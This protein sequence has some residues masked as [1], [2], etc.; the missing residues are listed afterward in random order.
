MKFVPPNTTGWVFFPR[1][2]QS[3]MPEGPVKRRKTSHG[4]AAAAM[5][6]KRRARIIPEIAKKSKKS[7]KEMLAP[8]VVV[9]SGLKEE[10][11]EEKEEGGGEGGEEEVVVE[12]EEKEE[13]KKKE[14]KQE[15]PEIESTPE[16]A[17]EELVVVKDFKELVLY[18]L[19]LSGKLLI[20]TVLQGVMDSLCEACANLGYKQ[21]T[22]IQVESIPVA[23]EGKDVIALAETGSGKTAA[24]ALPILQGQC[25]YLVLHPPQDPTDMSQPSGTTPRACL[26]AFSHLRVNS[27]S[28]SRI[29][30]RPSAVELACAV[31]SLLVVWT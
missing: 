15:V 14:K 2:Q 1:L 24:F 21:P 31:P 25:Y 11:E 17:A 7:K 8:V 3:A 16:P 29:N 6:S 23:L 13:E 30:S 26:P 9:E 20:R 27:P 28:R 10:K 19:T 18:F 4:A 12:K 5:V 22:P